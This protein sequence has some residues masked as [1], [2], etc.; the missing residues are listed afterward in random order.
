MLHLISKRI[1]HCITV[2]ISYSRRGSQEPLIEGKGGG[3]G[4]G[5]E[6]NSSK[7][8]DYF[9]YY[10]SHFKKS[11]NPLLILDK[12]MFHMCGTSS[13]LQKM[14][15]RTSNH[16]LYSCTQDNLHMPFCIEALMTLPKK[17]GAAI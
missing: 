9:I 11:L 1:Q 15:E 17:Y 14:D 4:G 12:G 6:I 2:S 10:M 5:G 8:A 16:R 3:G 7:E 13:V